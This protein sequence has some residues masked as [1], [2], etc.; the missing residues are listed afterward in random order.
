LAKT[1]PNEFQACVIGVDCPAQGTSPL[2][3]VQLHWK[4][5][6]IGDVVQY[7]L[8]RVTGAT[9]LPGSGQT[10]TLV[11]TVAAL[12]GQ[13]AYSAIDTTELID[14]ASYTYFVVAVYKDGVHSDTSNLVTIVAVNE[15]PVARA[16]SY[17]TPEDTT[18]TRGAPGVLGNDSDAD[19]AAALSAQLVAGPAHGTLA[20]NADGSFTYQPDADFN[21]SDSFTYKASHPSAASD[22]ATVTI[23]VTPVNDGPVARAD[24][25]S[26]DQGA[27]LTV[28]APG[29]LANDSDPESSLTASLHVAPA[30]GTVILNGDGSF[31]YTPAAGFAGTD[32][33]TYH[34]SDGALATLA[35]VTL[36]V[37]ASRYGFI[38]VQNLPPPAGKAF[39]IG[40]AVP[41]RWQFT[42]AGTVYNSINARP[43]ITVIS[44]S[45]AVIYQGTP[46]DPGSSSF[47]A[48]TAANNYT[49]QFNWQTKNLR[50]ET[51]KVFV[52][53]VQTGQVYAAGQAFGPFAVTLK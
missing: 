49:W 8:Y 51:Y 28:A 37:N 34:A 20:F 29:V 48:P 35:T 30:H 53:S 26:L 2:H 3:R 7:N 17:S 40:S 32:T 5:P 33:F 19:T 45:G 46:Q 10:W 13:P 16:D 4:T 39:K 25:Y 43:Q 36:T 6:N 12:L 47:Q 9:L 14:G 15:P 27:V 23:T 24:S 11:G 52:G 31:V 41:L 44:A 21:G 50:A 42:M 22:E 38:G 1:P 18:L